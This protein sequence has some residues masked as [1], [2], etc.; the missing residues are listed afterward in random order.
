MRIFEK[1]NRHSSLKEVQELDLNK[2]NPQSDCQEPFVSNLY[3]LI[4]VPLGSVLRGIARK[5]RKGICFVRNFPSNEVRFES[6]Q[7]DPKRRSV[8][9]RVLAT[10]NGACACLVIYVRWINYQIFPPTSSSIAEKIVCMRWLATIAPSGATDVPIRIVSVFLRNMPQGK[11]K[12]SA[13]N[14]WPAASV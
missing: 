3:L 5:G 8:Q 14:R 9:F 4:P 7:V 6:F 12:K 1:K 13:T 10:G 2:M 11:H